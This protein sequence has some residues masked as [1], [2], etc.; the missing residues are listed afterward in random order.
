ME[1]TTLL[2]GN[3]TPSFLEKVLQQAGLGVDE[4]IWVRIRPRHVEILGL[5]KVHSPSELTPAEFSA[6][7]RARRL[8]I[9]R[10][11]Y[12]IWSKDQEDAFQSLRDEIWSRWQTR[13]L[14]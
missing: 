6:E 10:R 11:L 5:K 4:T 3:A 8:R 14:E 9:V 7:E 13:D 2:E 12:G 1:E